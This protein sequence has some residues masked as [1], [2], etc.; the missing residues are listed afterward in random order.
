[1]PKYDKSQYSLK[2]VYS[3]YRKRCKERGVEPV[4]FKKHKL[5]LDTWGLKVVEY[6][7]AGKDVQ[8]H[9]GLASLQIRKKRVESYVDFK[10]SREAG[11]AV[12]K[13]NAHS[14]FFV[15]VVRWTRHY[16]KI[17][18]RGW[19]FIPSRKLVI[20]LTDVM[21]TPGGHRTF[22]QKARMT[23]HEHQRRSMYNKQI[24]TQ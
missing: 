12:R 4:D 24:L 16:T 19:K 1:M 14:G 2:K 21:K 3:H 13:S 23:R 15:S 8:L 10:A 9:S 7:A 5:I 6:L 18:S 11:K 22:V 17:H 20:K